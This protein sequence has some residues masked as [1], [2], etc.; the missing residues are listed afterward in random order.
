MSMQGMYQRVSAEVLNAL[1]SSS[2]DEI[3]QFVVD[4]ISEDEGTRKLQPLLDIDKA[5]H[6]LHFLL[7]G[8]AWEGKPPL[9]NAV[10]VAPVKPDS[11]ASWLSSRL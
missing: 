10:G 3:E 6:A 1:R 8:S 11:L 5:W 2:D 9:V 7:C 4:A